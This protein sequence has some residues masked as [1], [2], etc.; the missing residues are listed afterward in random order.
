MLNVMPSVILTS[1]IML[2]VVAPRQQIGNTKT[3]TKTALEKRKSFVFQRCDGSNF[4][5][6][7]PVTTRVGDLFLLVF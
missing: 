1:V 3:E 5:V 2:N 6:D 4:A 7:A